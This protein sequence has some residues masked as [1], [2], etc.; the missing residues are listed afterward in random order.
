[1]LKRLLEMDRA[2]YE[3]VARW[4]TPLLDRV[5]PRLSR[6][7]NHGVLWFG[8]AALMWAGG[9]KRERRA[10]LRGVV[11]LG[12]TS[13]VVNGPMKW[14]MRRS[15][16]DATGI[17]L[18]RRLTTA[19]RT[20]SF[21]S[22]HS[23][24]A[25]A[26]A[27][28]VGLERPALALP[29]VPLAAGVG[30]SRVYTGVH[31]PVD[32]AVGMAVGAT[33]AA[34]TTRFWPVPPEI[35]GPRPRRLPETGSARP[36]PDGA[37]VTIV[38]NPQSGPAWSAN[39]APAL[40]E[41]LPRAQV[42]EADPP[43]RMP[44]LLRS[45]DGVAV[46]GVAGGDGSVNVAAEVAHDKGVPLLV[47]P[48]GT[49]NHLARDLG[50]EDVDDAVAAV[51]AGTVVPLDI[52]EIDGRPFVNTAS[53]GV[54]PELV[55]ARERLERRIGKWPA[56]VVALVQVLAAGTPV[57]CEMDGVRRRVWMVFVGNCRYHP[58]GF[59]PSWR[60]RLDDGL[61]DLRWVEAGRP[62]SRTRLVAA[63]LTGRLGR[64]RV[65]HEARV[66]SLR[67]RSLQ[68][69]LRLARDGETFDGG[70]EFEIRKREG[71]LPVLVP[72]G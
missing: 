66:R 58:H 21:P 45:L 15:R 40:A 50:I 37:G 61:L 69:P 16:P 2:G 49:L 72:A 22:G 46:V 53:F 34:L 9:G 27:T 23:A 52:A 57:E 48:G 64:C 70:T 6:T 33:A 36:A 42:V 24:S 55:D 56:L 68:G 51:R 59:G 63:V 41:A 18:Q 11:S 30:V 32:V 7:A 62:W 39:P 25:A 19:P 31:Y 17:A 10:A 5:L 28:A 8:C 43:D 3:A 47:V 54:Y 67:V 26:F 20:T 44:D 65:H 14:T 13:A 60:E 35:A 1:V 71:T 12:I 29:L 38:V 4:E